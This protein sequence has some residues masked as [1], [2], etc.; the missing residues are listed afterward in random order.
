MAQIFKIFINVYLL[1][2]LN[3]SFR[4]LSKNKHY[5]E[6]QMMIYQNETKFNNKNGQKPLH[7]FQIILQ[8][9][10]TINCIQFSVL[11]E[12]LQNHTFLLYQLDSSLI[13]TCVRFLH[14]I[15]LSIHI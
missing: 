8:I 9:Q 12:H 2:R 14:L 5:N 11:F 15:H 1:S 7:S 13:F 4:C 3:N 10:S 6:E